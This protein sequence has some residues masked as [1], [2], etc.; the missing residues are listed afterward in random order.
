[1]LEVSHESL[2]IRKVVTV[3]FVIPRNNRS[4]ER[5]GRSGTWRLY[6]CMSETYQEET[7]GTYRYIDISTQEFG[8]TLKNEDLKVSISI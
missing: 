7:T 2:Y 5:V 3:R 4:V 6:S 1:M 8:V